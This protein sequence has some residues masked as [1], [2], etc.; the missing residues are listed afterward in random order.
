MRDIWMILDGAVESLFGAKLEFII[1]C[2]PSG[3]CGVTLKNIWAAVTTGSNVAQCT[4][5]G[6]DLD[7]SSLRHVCPL[8]SIAPD[9]LLCDTKIRFFSSEI[10]RSPSA[11]TSSSASISLSDALSNP[12]LSFLSPHPPNVPGPPANFSIQ[13]WKHIPHLYRELHW[14]T[15]LP[16]HFVSQVFGA[17]LP[18]PSLSPSLSPSPYLLIERAEGGTLHRLLHDPY[19]LS[20]IV[21]ITQ[22]HMRYIL[23][24]KLSEMRDGSSKESTDGKREKEREREREREGRQE[25]K[26]IEDIYTKWLEILD[27]CHTDKWLTESQISEM[28]EEVTR[29]RDRHK[30]NLF[31]FVVTR[32]RSDYEKVRG[33][34]DDVLKALHSH[35]PLLIRMK[36]CV[37]IR[38]ACD[39]I[40]CVA[41]LHSHIPPLR[42]SG[43]S[44]HSILLS[45][46][47]SFYLSSPHASN[48]VDDEIDN[49]ECD[50]ID[51]IDFDDSDTSEC[52]DIVSNSQMNPADTIAKLGNLKCVDIAS[53]AWETISL[54]GN[55]D[56]PY[57]ANTFHRSSCYWAPPEILRG[58]RCHGVQSDVYSLG[59]LLWEIFTGMH[60]F[61]SEGIGPNEI[62]DHVI[63]GG[64]PST[65][66]PFEQHLPRQLMNVLTSC[67]DAHPP[68]RPPIGYIFSAIRQ[69]AAE[70]APYLENLFVSLDPLP[71]SP[72]SAPSSLNASA[73]CHRESDTIHAD[74]I[75]IE[76]INI[77]GY[78]G[79]DEPV[80][81]KICSLAI[82]HHTL[83]WIGFENG[84]LGV[85][86]DVTPMSLCV[87][88]V[89]EKQCPIVLSSSLDRR[90]GAVKVLAFDGQRGLIWSGSVDGTISVWLS[91]P[92]NAKE[93][94]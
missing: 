40:R 2:D 6:P 15:S 84:S 12:P 70:R 78:L 89:T 85:F 53:N 26:K 44:S 32:D 92:L 21:H 93:V 18:L 3:E 43:L 68:L 1:P 16:L 5:M 28:R 62:R 55:L 66:P 37:R 76:K 74:V 31:R 64:R 27:R 41:S 38:I 9:I 11:M 61:R 71:P 19:G 33:I 10:L 57:L 72:A 4:R 91:R 51:G 58:A 52:D 17:A 80:D 54:D 69:I 59:V 65:S 7:R 73:V 94:R 81:F 67:W 90:S 13:K 42:H 47:L 77:F 45:R 50:I 36:M 25:W 29:F 49:I 24:K 22:D 63:Q 35:A 30:E 20:Q 56:L 34:S 75:G 14:M 88:G 39:V 82:A 87:S 60:P 8:T 46:P 86:W 83:L 79:R 48:D 23:E